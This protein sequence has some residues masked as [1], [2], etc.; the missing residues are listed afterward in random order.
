MTI[1]RWDPF[2]NLRE[3]FD[4]LFEEGLIRSPRLLPT[5]LGEWHLRLDMYETADA[6]VVKTP[7]PGVRPEDVEMT[8]TGDTLTIKGEVKAEAEVKR[9]DYFHQEMLYGGFH[10]IVSLPGALKTDKAEA[11]FENGILTLIIPKAEEAKPKA[12][13]VQVKGVVEGK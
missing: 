3:T 9:E 7:V 5:I 1:A 4:R 13:K 10:R 11:S 6:V 2:G 8:I 12:V